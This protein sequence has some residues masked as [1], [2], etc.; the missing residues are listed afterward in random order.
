MI[1]NTSVTACTTGK[2]RWKIELII[3]WPIPGSANTCSITS[4][5]PTRKPMFT[6]STLT[7]EMTAFR[8]AWRNSTRRSGMPFERAVV[9]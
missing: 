6:P 4:V 5:P 1:P 9:M 3:S 7:V 2:S 8:I